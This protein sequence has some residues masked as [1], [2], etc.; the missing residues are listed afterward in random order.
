MPLAILDMDG[1]LYPG[2][3]ASDMIQGLLDAEHGHKETSHAIIE[4]LQRRKKRLVSQS[5]IVDEFYQNYSRTLNGVEHSHVRDVASK[6]WGK[7][8]EH[9]FAYV[10]PALSKLA[11]CGYQT[12][13][14]SGS[15]QEIIDIAIA[16]LGINYGIGA[17]IKVHEG[18]CVAEL[19][20]APA[21]LG[22]KAAL[23]I[24][25][26]A[27]IEQDLQQSL[28]IGDTTSDAE[29]F[30]LVQH[31]IAFEPEEALTKLAHSENWKIVDRVTVLPHLFTLLHGGALP[32]IGVRPIYHRT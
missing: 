7:A 31:A 13:L 10:R 17:R 11:A 30:Q 24:A 28:A 20:T 16:D 18:Y 8:R 15:P 25:L 3:L 27:R 6:V 23:L 12:I 5:T 4:A 19:L 32:D 26:I 22:Q 1:T 9:L 14:I 29:V 2:T 21:R